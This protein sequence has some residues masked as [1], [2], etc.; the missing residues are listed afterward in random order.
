MV[1]CLPVFVPRVLLLLFVNMQI[2]FTSPNYLASWSIISI[3]YTLDIVDND[4]A[5]SAVYSISRITPKKKQLRKW[6]GSSR[7]QGVISS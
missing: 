1:Q 7:T 6:T 5:L 2:A 4:Q 3:E